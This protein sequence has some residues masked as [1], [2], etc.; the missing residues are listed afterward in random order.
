[1]SV[2]KKIRYDMQGGVRNYLGKQKTVSDVPVK[3]K[4]GPDKPATELAYITKAEKDLLLKK[5]IH[6]SLKKGPNEGP[7]GIMSLDSA[8]DKDGPVGGY[9]GADVSAAETGKAVKGMSS[10]DLAGFRAGAIAAGATPGL[11]ETQAVKNQVKALQ[12]QYGPR[13][14]TNKFGFLSPRNIFTGLLGL[15]NPALGLFGKAFG[16]LSDKAQDLRGYDEFGN[17]LSQEDYEKARRDRQLT[18]RLDNLYDRK[19]SGKN[20]SQKNIDMLESMGVTTS[21]GNIKSAIDRDLEINPEMPQ[22]ATSY[23]SSLAQPDINNPIG[24]RQVNIPNV[25]KDITYG[26]YPNSFDYLNVS[27]K[28]LYGT[29]NKSVSPSS[30]SSGYKGMAPT[31]IQTIDVGFNDPAFN[32]QLMA[33]ASYDQQKNILENIL[34]TEETGLDDFINKKEQEQK[35]QQE[36]FNQILTG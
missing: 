12:K 31:G 11:N 35:R 18:N 36:L 15:I 21:K 8:G 5:D 3:W 25:T 1:M 26:D 20:F 33:D 23:L 16:Y 13:V 9:S 30:F 17:P 4:S 27:D 19:L 7:G 22:F 10:K 34:N 28:D 24:P 32:N 29:F 14:G 2:D 6:G